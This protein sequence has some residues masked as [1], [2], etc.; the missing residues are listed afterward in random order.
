MGPGLG[1]D[2]PSKT[3][4]SSRV[5]VDEHSSES[6]LPQGEPWPHPASPGH[7]PR[8]AGRSGLGSCEVTAFALG[9]GTC[10]TLCASSKNGVS[11][12][13]SPV[14]LLQSSPAGLQSQ[15][16]WGLLP[17]MPDPQAGEPDMGLRTLT[18]VG[19]LLQYNY[20]PV[21]GLPTQRLWALFIL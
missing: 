2:D 19:E 18:P 10:K 12:S 20:S 15:M 16:L 8:L 13:P 14:E 7:P 21:C 6:P 3:S 17:L 9:P 4:A 1:A 5:H 11:A